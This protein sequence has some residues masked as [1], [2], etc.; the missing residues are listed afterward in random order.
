MGLGIVTAI[1]HHIFYW[2]LNQTSVT[3]MT[4]R[5]Q[6]VGLEKSQQ[7]TSAL[8]N[9]LAIIVKSS[10]A[11]AI[12]VAFAQAFWYRMRKQA[13]S[14]EKINSIIASKGS[15]L[16]LASWAA[17]RYAFWLPFIAL[18]GF[19]M[20]ILSVVAP[21]ALSVVQSN[22]TVPHPCTVYTVQLGKTD[23]AGLGPDVNFALPAMTSLAL[24][25]LMVGSY[26][27]PPSPCGVC[28]YQVKFEAPAFNCIDIT[29]S[30]DF[31]T[32]FAPNP[33]GLLFWNTSYAFMPTGLD[34]RAAWKSDWRLGETL[35]SYHAIQCVAS[36]VT[37]RVNVT[38]SATEST[39]Q[40]LDRTFHNPLTMQKTWDVLPFN[41]VMD[42]VATLLKGTVLYSNRSWQLQP[43]SSLVG[44]GFGRYYNGLWHWNV[45]PTEAVPQLMENVSLSL[46]SG[47]IS[48]LGGSMNTLLPVKETCYRSALVYR[49]D[50]VRLLLPYA[51]GLVITLLCVVIGFRVVKRNGVEESLDFKRIVDAILNYDMVE[52]VKGMEHMPLDANIRVSDGQFRGEFLAKPK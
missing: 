6:T 7:L 52:L 23:I 4:F 31:A 18:L 10:F 12:G 13:F 21:G 36:N 22:F 48:V 30:Y 16:A 9:A 8:G 26:L 39:F 32:T 42:S 3:S 43:G 24:K 17:W 37:Y 20:V 47:S 27:P 51:S 34:L 15:P 14:V 11:S 19:S 49:Y 25:V 29:T 5:H 1:A 2:R 44:Y 38:H 41:A 50:S 35:G 40:V 46:L 33:A 28:R 45:D